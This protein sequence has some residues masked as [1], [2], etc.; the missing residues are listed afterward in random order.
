M[1]SKQQLQSPINI[2]LA[3]DDIDDCH[4]FAQALKEIPIDTQLA[5]VRDGDLLMNY[6]SV[7]LFRLPDILFLDLSMPRKT[8]FECLSEIR[9][10]EKYNSIH[11]IMF[12]TSYPRD[13][14]YE[15]SLIKSLKMLGGNNFIRKPGDFMKIKK[16]L[17]DILLAAEERKSKPDQNRNL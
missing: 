9:E 14:N 13:T 6:L 11:I 10:N 12:S 3:D 15:G 2:L 5:I 4:I 8:G 1:K 17:H 7:N 16:I